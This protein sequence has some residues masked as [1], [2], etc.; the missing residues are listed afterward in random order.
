[1]KSYSKLEKLV[2]NGDLSIT[3]IDAPPRTVSTALFRSL[4]QVYD[5]AIFEPLK[6]SGENAE[7]TFKDILQAAEEAGVYEQNKQKSVKVLVKVI[8][9]NISPEEFK[10]VIKLS[11]NYIAVVR[12]PQ[13]QCDSL[14][15][16]AANNIDK[17]Q[18][19]LQFAANKVETHLGS[20][21]KAEKVIAMEHFRRTGWEKL[22]QHF[23][24][25]QQVLGKKCMVVDGFILRANP[26][27]SMINILDKLGIK[28]TEN[29]I[30]QLV[31]D[32]SKESG[33]K[34]IQI[35]DRTVKNS[36]FLKAVAATTGYIPPLDQTKTIGDFPEKYQDH[37]KE[38]ALPIYVDMLKS[39]NRI[40]AQNIDEL[41]GLF[42]TEIGGIKLI[43]MNPVS[44]YALVTALNNRTCSS[45]DKKQTLDLYRK[46]Y[47]A[48]VE[49]FDVIAKLPESRSI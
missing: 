19:N 42:N 11:D 1:M 13:L 14:I 41:K 15:N 47:P 37:I 38:I 48:Y 3:Y 16:K 40:G 5:G 36:E 23:D 33:D 28:H 45:T 35:G 27:K 12:D 46:T 20:V 25:A 2:R 43:D 24:I 32:W 18:P 34:I 39:G 7:N 29:T 44:A 17:R 9:S 22:K 6:I 30:R 4:S 10:G 49:S 8:A 21:I 31:S 26:E